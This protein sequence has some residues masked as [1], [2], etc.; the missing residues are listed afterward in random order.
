M[1]IITFLNIPPEYNPS[2]AKKDG[3]SVTSHLMYIL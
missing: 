1:Q 2:A 3:K